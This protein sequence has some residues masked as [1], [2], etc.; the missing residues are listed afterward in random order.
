MRTCKFTKCAQH[1]LN[2]FAKNTSLTFKNVCTQALLY[3]I[4]HADMSTQQ[5]S[6]EVMKS[7]L[8]LHVQNG[9]MSILK[10]FF[11]YSKKTT[12]TWIR[13]FL[14]RAAALLVFLV[15]F[16]VLRIRMMSVTPTFAV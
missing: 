12:P 3:V 7:H 15:V 4:C 10:F 2:S 8:G 16:M 9:L 1:T 11:A 14:K 5:N 13:P 6:C